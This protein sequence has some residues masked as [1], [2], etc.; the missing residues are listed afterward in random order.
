MAKLLSAAIRDVLANRL[1]HPGSSRSFFVSRRNFLVGTFTAAVTGTLAKAE[2]FE[3]KL[4]LTN[5]GVPAK[6]G[7]LAKVTFRGITWE[8]NANLFGKQAQLTLVKK[9]D[10]DG[11]LASA[12]LNF[13]NATFPGLG[14]RADFECHIS[15]QNGR[16]NILIKPYPINSGETFDLERWIANEVGHQF[17]PHPQVYGIGNSSRLIARGANRSI[18]WKKD[19]AP[20]L[21]D[22]D[23][24]IFY[25]DD[26][27]VRDEP[28]YLRNQSDTFAFAANSVTFQA[29]E[30]V[31]ELLASLRPKKTAGKP[32]SLTSLR[33]V[34]SIFLGRTNQQQTLRIELFGH[35]DESAGPDTSVFI[36]SYGEENQ[37]E[38]LFI[39]DGQGRLVVDGPGDIPQTII[40]LERFCILGFVGEM[41]NRLV[42][43]AKLSRSAFQLSSNKPVGQ[44]DNPGSGFGL[45]AESLSLNI[46]GNDEI[47]VQT[48]GSKP[49]AALLFPAI[50][51]KAHIPVKG[52][53]SANLTFTNTNIDIVI[54]DLPK[55]KITPEAGIPGAI[56]KD[57]FHDKAVA[58]DISAGILGSDRFT[59]YTDT[60]CDAQLS[61]GRKSRFRAPLENAR[62]HLARSLDLFDLKFGF[63][64]YD[65]L[66]AGGTSHLRPR[67]AFL[68][69]PTNSTK[70]RNKPRRI[71][72]FAPQHVQEEVWKVK[73]ST[74]PNPPG[75]GEFEDCILEENNPPLPRTREPKEHNSF[76]LAQTRVAAPTRLVFEEPDNDTSAMRNTE[77]TI[78]TITDWTDLALVVHERALPRDATLE[79]QLKVVGIT[80]KTDRDEARSLV[81]KS[82][83]EPTRWQSALEPVTGLIFSPDAS[84]K[85]LTPRRPPKGSSAVI[86]RADLVKNSNTAVRALYARGLDDRFLNNLKPIDEDKGKL[87]FVT[88]LNAKDRRE[89]VAMSSVYGLAALRRLLRTENAKGNFIDDPKGMVIRPT[90]EYAFLSK[91]SELYPPDGKPLKQPPQPDAVWVPQEGIMIPKPFV[92]F[93]LT[94]TSF[95]STMRT[96]WEG[97]PPAPFDPLKGEEFF[98][99]AFRIESYVHRT[100]YGRDALVQVT[101]KGFLFPL[102]HRAAYIKLSERQF[103][104]Y[105][106]NP[107]GLYPTGYLVQRHF[108]VVRKPVKTFPALNQQNTSRAFPVKQVEILTT[109]TP[110]LAKPTEINLKAVGDGIC[111][112]IHARIFW[113]KTSAAEGSEVEFD[114][115][116]DGDDTPASSKLIFVDNAAAHDAKAM[117]ELVKK[118]NGEMSTNGLARVNHRGVD[119]KYAATGKAGETS[120]K[121]YDWELNAEGRATLNTSGDTFEM[122]ALMEGQDQPP[123]YPVMRTA[124]INN[125]SVDRLLGK[126]KGPLTVVFNPE[127]YVRSGFDPVRNPSEIYLNV[128]SPHI[129]LDFTK[130]GNTSGGIAKPN[131]SLAAIS[132]RVGL[133]GGT[134]NQSSTTRSIQSANVPALAAVPDAAAERSTQKLDITFDKAKSGEFDPFEFLPDGKILGILEIRDIVRVASIAAAPKLKEVYQFGGELAAELINTLAEGGPLIADAINATI[135]NADNAIKAT[136]SDSLDTSDIYPDLVKQLK[137]FAQTASKAAKIANEQKGNLDTSGS[138]DEELFKAL[139]PPATELYQE[140]KALLSE[141]ENVVANPTPAIV[142]D[143]I[144]QFHTYK[145]TIESLLK[146]DP[147]KKLFGYMKQ[148][149]F[150]QLCQELVEKKTYDLLFG[151]IGFNETTDVPYKIPQ[152]PKPLPKPEPTEEQLMRACEEMLNHPEQVLPNLR[153][154]LFYEVYG[155]ATSGFFVA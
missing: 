44:P 101:Y 51:H 14:K 117:A 112:P 49:I 137:V 6:T 10:K 122:D 150:S 142:G 46:R 93:D 89:L 80:E 40:Q 110:D 83:T 13:E 15:R 103:L 145:K 144:E 21:S 135:K 134:L 99:D 47:V 41:D 100:S 124:K 55:E 23:Q 31:S 26:A 22:R 94:L 33:G 64:H 116:L 35:G 78:E 37:R 136:F 98:R 153:Q 88:T 77:I 107:D 113:P 115:R 1:K 138:N 119:R 16:W 56:E 123:F 70:L 143:V 12:Q 20:V 129:K 105:Q 58:A 67:W 17:T 133:I 42:F 90:E 152:F 84:A 27:S 38:G 149:V 131:A 4:T 63:Q 43:G 59:R 11:R 155:Q 104:P 92:D 39:A 68:D 79:Q 9:V 75:A 28:D 85:F 121:T 32:S 53:S 74:A 19:L 154:S 81:S 114:Y 82:L 72:Y 34:E 62:L 50:L 151:S 30:G 73:D 148:E 2:I 86:W 146:S 87:P 147:L 52:A 95:R 36:E 130:Q 7:D 18:V 3:P 5:K 118:Y 96:R 111:P 54:G 109:V 125:Q 25:V 69:C 66:V 140:G 57:W 29:R 141:I 128:L 45:E 61:I 120:F 127:L 8:I 91:E 139:Y 65:L 126:P 24:N 76:N 108:I 71:A 60:S 132:R 97:E 48:F 102:G 106:N